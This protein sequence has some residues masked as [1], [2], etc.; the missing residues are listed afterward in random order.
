VTRMRMTREF[1]QVIPRLPDLA[2]RILGVRR[3]E[4]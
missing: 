2:R 1:N 4:I 3:M